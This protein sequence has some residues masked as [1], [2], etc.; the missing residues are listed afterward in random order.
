[1]GSVFLQRKDRWV[2][3]RARSIHKRS[4]DRSKIRAHYAHLVDHQT[5][6]CVQKALERLKAPGLKYGGDTWMPTFI[7]KSPVFKSNVAPYSIRLVVNA[8]TIR[9]HFEKGT[10]PSY[11]QRFEI[12]NWVFWRA[13]THLVGCVQKSCFNFLLLFQVDCVQERYSLRSVDIWRGGLIKL[14]F[15][16]GRD[17]NERLSNERR[18]CDLNNGR[19][20]WPLFLLLTMIA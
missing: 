13:D 11:Q 17:V 3:N 1:M 4:H 10:R 2:F 8:L 14:V 12:Q 16:G 18:Y 20:R 7:F 15:C 6:I 9:G 19:F 5:L